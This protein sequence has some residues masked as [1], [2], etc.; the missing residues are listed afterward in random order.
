M[1]VQYENKCVWTKNCGRQSP[2]TGLL[3]VSNE[4]W[5]LGV[6]NASSIVGAGE[7]I[8]D[9]VSLIVDIALWMGNERDW[10]GHG[11]QDIMR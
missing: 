10:I 4:H 8:L 5:I 2:I 6:E 9:Y 11:V 3:V 1:L 7:W